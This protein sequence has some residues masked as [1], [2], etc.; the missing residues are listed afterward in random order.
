[1]KKFFTVLLACSCLAV[2]SG[3]AG[4]EPGVGFDQAA[5]LQPESQLEQILMQKSSARTPFSR[6]TFSSE[7]ATSSSQAASPSAA[8]SSPSS[9]ASSRSVTSSP[10]TPSIPTASYI[11]QDAAKTAALSHAG[12]AA[13]N[14]VFT[15]VQQDYENGRVV[16]E[17]DFYSGNTEYD[18]EIDATT[19]AV[20][21]FDYETD[22]RAPVTSNGGT[23][24]PNGGTTSQ[25]TNYI[26]QD[27]AKFIA[28]ST[29]G[30]STSQVTFT[31]QSLDYDDGRAVYEIDFISGDM[32]YDF[33]ID[34]VS[35]T[36]IEY[37][38]ESIYDD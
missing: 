7:A 38:R 14:A 18:Y 31:K 29:A 8:A 34:A 19:A 4:E 10:A 27:Q 25:S 5:L 15:K 16:Y 23:T 32:E 1:M 35:G 33:E 24:P 2:L 20:L 3:C 30:L 9:P 11:N 37:D 13:A 6:D 17:I 21:S 36:V 26:S 12:V 22:Y 28:L